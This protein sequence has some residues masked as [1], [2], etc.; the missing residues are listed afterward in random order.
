[1]NLG[2]NNIVE[3]SLTSTSPDASNITENQLKVADQLLRFIR[4][5]KRLVHLD[6]TCT[7]IS[8]AMFLHMLPGIKKSRS[9][10]A[11]HFSGNPGVTKH[12]K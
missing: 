10:M 4:Y 8:E 11:V 12:V 1:M 6:L 7:N 3:S 2:Y 9:L 5:G